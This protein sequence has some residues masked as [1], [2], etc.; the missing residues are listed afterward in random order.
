MKI[1]IHTSTGVAEIDA[2]ELKIK[3]TKGFRHFI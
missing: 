3:R 1:K 2:K